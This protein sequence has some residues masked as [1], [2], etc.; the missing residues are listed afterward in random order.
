MANRDFGRVRV[1]LDMPSTRCGLA[2]LRGNTE[3]PA[4]R[5]S[6]PTPLPLCANLTVTT[7]HIHTSLLFHATFFKLTLHTLNTAPITTLSLA[8]IDLWHYDWALAL[9]LLTLPRRRGPGGRAIAPI[10]VHDLTA[11]L[12][13]H[14]L[15]HTLDPSWHLPI[16]GW[17]AAKGAY[18][19]LRRVGVRTVRSS[20]HTAYM[21]GQRALLTK[22]MEERMPSVEFDSC[23][24]DHM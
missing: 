5:V 9:P 16:G 24:H 2:V 3:R 18:P 11:F 23:A 12:A 8:C 21:A 19:E 6:A 22:F 7:L 20:D 4:Q 10:P 1:R 15:I 14:P 13:R 17:K